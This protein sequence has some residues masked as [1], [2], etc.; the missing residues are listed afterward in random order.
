M[1][2][3]EMLQHECPKE[4]YSMI[5]KIAKN[6]QFMVHPKIVNEQM[7]WVTCK[8]SPYFNMPHQC[9]FSLRYKVCKESGE[10]YLFDYDEMHNHLF[11]KDCGQIPFP[12]KH[13]ALLKFPTPNFERNFA[14]LMA[15]DGK[16]LKDNLNKMVS[17]LGF[18]LKQLLNFENYLYLSCNYTVWGANENEVV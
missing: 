2:D 11:G 13:K 12:A 3:F 1:E 9:P 4:I 18:G 7:I 17:N 8:N 15:R 14:K 6:K 16:E 5:K 10:F